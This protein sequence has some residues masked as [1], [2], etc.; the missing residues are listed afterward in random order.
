MLIYR[1]FFFGLLGVFLGGLL[2]YLSLVWLIDPVGVWGTPVIRGINH[3]KVNQGRFLDVYKP[4][5]YMREKPDVLYIGASG[6]YVGIEPVSKTDKK[7]YNMGLSLLTLPDM[8]EYLRFIYKVHKPEVIY[9]GLIPANFNPNYSIKITR[10]GFSRERLERLAGNRWEYL[11]QIINDSMGIHDVYWST[12]MASWV[13]K[14]KESPFLRGWDVKRGRAD[15]PIPKEYYN[16]IWYSI[17]QGVVSADGSNTGEFAVDVECWRTIVAEAKEAGVH[18]VA[19]FLPYSIDV[20]ALS[21]ISESRNYFQRL[22]R[23][24]AKIIPIY[25]FSIVSELTTNRQKY[26]YDTVHFRA[27]LGEKL[28]SCLESGDPT[29]YGYLLTQEN[30]DAVFEAENRAWEQWAVEN[31]EYVKALKA[32]IETGRKPEVGEFSEYIGF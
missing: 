30:A 8:R 22:K 28:K 4:Y 31:R 14:E 7:V 19:F 25:D 5:E 6:I 16:Y 32:C 12:V 23:E 27:S 2:A 3:Y 13:H 9:V 11:W 18:L 26:Y 24:A 21:E 17:R 15:T 10:Q 20:Y 29:P 1:K